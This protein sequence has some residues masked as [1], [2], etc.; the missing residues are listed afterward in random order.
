MV[1]KAIIGVSVIAVIIVAAVVGVGISTNWFAP[2]QKSQPHEVTIALNMAPPSLEPTS[3]TG[4]QL[5]TLC[6]V[7][8]DRLVE[9]SPN[10]TIV[11]GLARS[12]TTSSDGLTWTF[13]LRSSIKFSDGTVCDASAVAYNINK[14]LTEKPASAYRLFM[15][16][17]QVTVINSTEVQFTTNAPWAPLLTNLAYGVASIA[18]PAA[19]QAHPGNYS[20]YASGTGPYKLVSY[21][22][23]SRVEMV[24]N[25]YY[26]GTTPGLDRL[27]F[28]IV[29][30]PSTRAIALETGDVQISDAVPLPQYQLLKTQSDIVTAL[31]YER[32]CEYML[33]NRLYNKYVRLALNYAVNKTAIVQDLF[34][35]SAQV[36]RTPLPPLLLYAIHN[37]TIYNYNPTLA[38][39]LL[40][41]GGYP[42][43]L[44]ITLETT[45]GAYP[46]DAEVAQIVQNQLKAIGV[47]LKIVYN[48]GAQQSARQSSNPETYPQMTQVCWG[49]STGDPDYIITSFFYGDLMPPLS[50]NPGYSNTTVNNLIRQ[51]QITVDPVQRE[52]IYAKAQQMIWQDAPDIWLYVIPEVYAWTTNVHGVQV[53]PTGSIDLRLATID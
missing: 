18:S 27:T 19:Y 40:A 16:I 29:T 50:K 15:N 6:F 39:Q 24:P 33:N 34:G 51:G 52:V 28:L 35:G 9:L 23:G 47:N 41:Q 10:L 46:Y 48:T 2:P 31:L 12:W 11:P 21:I 53:M 20:Y 49:T 22:P 32:P 36:S 3:W 44:N 1:S 4:I 38:K 30:D 25:S 42:N 37:N 26:W 5:Q 45:N 17:T 8:Y 14:I 43:G 13:Y 7:M